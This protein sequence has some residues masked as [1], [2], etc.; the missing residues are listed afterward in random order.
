MPFLIN[1]TSIYVL[2]SID[3]NFA[4]I[5]YWYTNLTCKPH[6]HVIVASLRLYEKMPYFFFAIEPRDN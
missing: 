2:I 4:K 1:L 3:V 5:N 6:L